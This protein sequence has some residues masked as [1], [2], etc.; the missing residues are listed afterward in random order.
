MNRLLSALLL[1]LV[2]GMGTA[3]AQD[4][5]VSG[6][7]KSESGEPLIAVNVG[8]KGTTSGT[9]TDIDGKFSLKIPASATKLVFSFVG[10]ETQEVELG[11]QTV[12]DVVLVEN[13]A[14]LEEVVIS[15]LATTIKR[16][17][18]ANAVA[19]IPASAISGTTT[20]QTLD[21]ALYGKFK[22]ANIVANSGAP[23]GG[24]SIKLR[25][26]TSITGSSQP[27]YIVDG[28]YLDN[29]AIPG[30]LNVVSAAAA[31]GSAS[32]QDNPSNRIADLA[33]EDI[34][35][36]EILKGASAASIYGSRSAAG[37]VIITTKKGA[38][39]RTSITFD[40]NIGFST[41]LNPLGQRQ[42]DTEKVR[43][44]FG[45]AEAATFSAAQA[46]GKVYDYEQELYG[47]RG[48]LRNTSVTVSGGNE[49][50]RFYASVHDKSEEAIVKNT[51]YERTSMRLNLTHDISDRLELAVRTN[52]ITS[53][54]DRGFFNNDNS[55]TTMGISFVSTRPWAD[56]FPDA[57]GNYPNNPYAPSNFLQTRDLVV[58]NETV[59]RFIGG[60]TLTAT[61]QQSETSQLKFIG[62]LGLDT[63]TLSTQALFS[64]ELQFQKEGNGVGGVSV[65]GSTVVNN[66]N[67]Q[68]FLVHNYFPTSTLSFTSQVGVLHLSFDRN[69]ILGTATNLIGT[70]TNLDQAGSVAIEQTRQPEEDFGFFVQEEVN[71]DDKVL[72]TVGL[73]AD[74]SS[75][76]GDA[77]KLY[78]Y[79]KANVAVNIHEFVSMGPISQFKIR[80]AYGQAGRFANFGST[81]TSLGNVIIDGQAGSLINT[82]R[83]NSTV[84]PERQS[85]IETGFDVAFLNNRIR[86][87]A[88]YYRKNVT[89]LLLNAQVPTS[90]GFSAR[91]L[92][93]A[94][95]RNQG[96]ELGLEADVVGKDDLAW[97][98][99]FNF[100]LNRSKVTRLDVPA[101]NTGA[102][103]ATLGTFRVEEGKSA[104]QIVGIS[105][106]GLKVFGDAEPAFQ[107]SWN[108]VIKVKNFD[109]SFLF[110]WKQGSENV[111]L[112][113][114]LFD[115]NGTTPDYD[116]K[117]LDPEGT[118]VNGDYRLSQLGSSAQVFV[119]DA[120]YIRLREIGLFYNVNQEALG[121]VLGGAFKGV[122]VGVSAYNLL[123]FFSYNSY[124]PEVSNF[125]SGGL[126]TGVEV[127]PFPSSK[128]LYFHLSLKF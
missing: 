75:N 34:E 64:R 127:T 9:V 49:R 111:N 110:H 29:S 90:S 39:G 4:R 93:A 118:L 99:G 96:I 5:T 67:A 28:V 124:D 106:D 24:A 21:G 19:S 120:S 89:D 60:A 13:L 53:S 26:V 52:Y 70:Q 78:Y 95:L 103:G 128:R 122:R 23:G 73:R 71:F 38:P 14:A 30:G 115:L 58:N 7:V 86:F 57:N 125:G 117:T 62:S 18:L 113:T 123:N 36:I 45:D 47:H 1:F 107:L 35:S 100:W 68:A 126:S 6:T 105:P 74:K 20:Q 10:Y 85:E 46:A 41:M 76:N 55:G 51:G 104:T 40:Q 17:N 119:E 65:Q 98:T 59:R 77:N 48:M 61:L 101:F 102:F 43:S 88:T 69:T 80:A 92:N 37:V 11:N 112:S 66:R 72:F 108:N 44:V 54:A 116:E 121:S 16:S 91:V 25:G 87:D 3:W 50:T 22:G 2:L 33:P 84:G 27:L 12:I 79:P 109:L 83:G 56:L 82:L 114:L 81:F 32:N 97:T 63:Y 94:D 15:G 42:W 31:G 8:V